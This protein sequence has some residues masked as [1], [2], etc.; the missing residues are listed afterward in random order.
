MDGI[1]YGGVEVKSFDFGGP[2]WLGLRL[3]YIGAFDTYDTT[4]EDE[5]FE[6]DCRST[7]SLTLSTLIQDNTDAQGVL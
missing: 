4:F 7:V 6:L 1:D 3:G 5:K 2:K